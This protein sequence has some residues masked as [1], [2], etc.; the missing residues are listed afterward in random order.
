M[1]LMF[2]RKNR[3][4]KKSRDVL[5][6]IDLKMHEEAMRLE[7]KRRKNKEVYLA[8]LENILDI[9]VYSPAFFARAI[10]SIIKQISLNKNTN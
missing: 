9:F 6:D 1:N 7:R 3:K 4:N 2:W 8:W 10:S 5:A